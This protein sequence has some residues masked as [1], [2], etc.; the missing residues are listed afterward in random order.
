MKLAVR[1]SQEVTDRGLVFLVFFQI[2]LRT[3]EQDLVRLYDLHHFRVAGYPLQQMLL[4]VQYEGGPGAAPGEA[5]YRSPAAANARDALR[6]EQAVKEGCR[7]LVATFAEL[8]DFDDTSEHVFEM[9][10]TDEL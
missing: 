4:G 2:V 3:D 6:A 9:P 1:R 7:D 5:Q 8:R 10:D